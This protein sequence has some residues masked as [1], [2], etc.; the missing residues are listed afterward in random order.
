MT[1][2]CSAQAEEPGMP[3]AACLPGT[4]SAGHFPGWAGPPQPQAPGS[5]LHGH[6]APLI[7]LTLLLR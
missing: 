4:E 7:S 1:L 3:A 2:L 6:V 5:L